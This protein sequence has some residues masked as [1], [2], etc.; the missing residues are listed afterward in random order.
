M[1]NPIKNI[2]ISG[3]NFILTPDGERHIKLIPSSMDINQLGEFENNFFYTT[4]NSQSILNNDLKNN[5]YNS[6]LKNFKIW[7][8]E[9]KNNKTSEE[10]A[11]L[12]KSNIIVP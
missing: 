4:K 12:N 7:L 5:N 11:L 1:E 8:R 3:N 2:L 6:L 10:P 9:F